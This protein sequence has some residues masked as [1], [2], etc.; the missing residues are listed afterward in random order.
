M[1]EKDAMELSYGNPLDV[2]RECVKRRSINM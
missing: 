2:K 1:Y